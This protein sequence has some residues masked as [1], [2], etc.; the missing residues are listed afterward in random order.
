MVNSKLRA[1]ALLSHVHLQLSPVQKGSRREREG[2]TYLRKGGHGI[3][4]GGILVV[5]LAV[6]GAATA[7][8]AVKS[9]L[10]ELGNPEP[11]L[12]LPRL[13]RTALLALPRSTRRHPISSHVWLPKV[14]ASHLLS[15]AL[16]SVTSLYEPTDRCV[17][18]PLLVL[19]IASKSQRELGRREKQR[20]P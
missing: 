19:F 11:S 17:S 6:G 20:V 12:W 2:F 8:H 10:L 13:V 5:E 14:T 15:S 9:N 7:T 18:S 1:S 3:M 16:F 4:I